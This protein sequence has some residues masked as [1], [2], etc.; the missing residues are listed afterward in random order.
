MIDDGEDFTINEKEKNLIKAY[1][2]LEPL[3]QTGIHAYLKGSLQ[4]KAGKMRNKALKKQ[5]EKLIK[6][7]EIEPTP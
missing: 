5:I 4:D 7:M 6:E 1:R 2:L 3:S